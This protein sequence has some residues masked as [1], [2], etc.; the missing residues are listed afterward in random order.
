MGP[1]AYREVFL[2]AA[3]DPRVDIQ[4]LIQLL[5]HYES[6]ATAL[7]LA[8]PKDAAPY[9]ELADAAREVVE[10]TGKPMAL[11]LP[12]YKQGIESLNVEELIRE[13]RKAFLERGIPV[14]D[15]LGGCL[16]ALGN[17]SRYYASRR[18]REG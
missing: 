17:V 16:Q 1:Q 12:N 13:A 5:Y 15:D 9:R 6:V 10:A 18:A 3:R 7:G 11:V 4:V 8:S 14:F 2:L